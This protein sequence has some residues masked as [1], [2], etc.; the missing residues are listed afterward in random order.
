M[1]ENGDDLKGMLE[2][3]GENYMNGEDEFKRMVA[4]FHSENCFFFKLYLFYGEL[5]MIIT[6]TISVLLVNRYLS[7]LQF[8]D[9]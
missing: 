4:K 7:S 5:L 1:E 8:P 2:Q 3:N 9:K 6:R